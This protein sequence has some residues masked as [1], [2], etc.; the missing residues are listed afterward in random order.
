MVP[1]GTSGF[2]SVEA[3]CPPGEDPLGGG[4]SVSGGPLDVIQSEPIAGPGINGAWQVSGNI[5]SSQGASITVWAVC[6]KAG[7]VTVG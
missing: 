2:A 7:S 3:L 6:A 5:T 1:A 4:Y